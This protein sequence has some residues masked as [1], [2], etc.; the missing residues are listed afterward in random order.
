MQIYL[1]GPEVFLPDAKA[2][3]EAKRAICA[4]HGA[5]GIFPLDP[6]HCPE[7]DACAEPWLSIYLRNEAHIRR[8]DA[9]IANLTPF[10]SP[11]ADA[12]TVY[13]LGFMRALGR[14][15]AAY[16]NSVTPFTERTRAFLGNAARQRPDGEWEDSEG[17]QLESF[18]LHDNLM[19]DGGIR[20]AGGVLVRQAVPEA[21]RWRNLDAFEEALRAV[22]KSS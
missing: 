1:A 9:L 6:V 16:A 20:A 15:I 19:I 2:L 17:L 7:A 18:G 3:G 12:G 13:E 21:E 11:S 22:M 14:P 10:R 5:T 8:A 4:R